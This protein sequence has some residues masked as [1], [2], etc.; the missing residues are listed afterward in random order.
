M[1]SDLSGI[2]EGFRYS[3]E[4][5]ARLTQYRFPQTFYEGTTIGSFNSWMRL[6]TGVLFGVGAGWFLF[7][8]LGTALSRPKHKTSDSKVAL[9]VD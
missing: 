7:S 4:W 5:L 1:V 8:S 2:G 3:N 9:Q 6:I